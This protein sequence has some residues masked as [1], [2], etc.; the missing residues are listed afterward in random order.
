[1]S[2]GEEES[3]R[4]FGLQEGWHSGRIN[5]GLLD[6]AQRMFL[7]G[8]D[9]LDDDGDLVRGLDDYLVG[10][11]H[12]DCTDMVVRVVAEHVIKHHDGRM[13]IEYTDGAVFEIEVRK[14]GVDQ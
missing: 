6:P 13:R 3:R 7:A 4:Y 11:R 9:I 5:V 14:S 8:E 1:M 10:L 2:A 12:E